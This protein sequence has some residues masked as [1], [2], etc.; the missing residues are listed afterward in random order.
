MQ[1]NTPTFEWKI[2]SIFDNDKSTPIFERYQEYENDNSMSAIFERCQEYENNKGTS[3][4]LSGASS[5]RTSRGC[6]P[7]WAVLE[8]ETL[9]S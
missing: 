7:F 4:I 9:E 2:Q 6:L 3:T 5:T 1:I 8:F